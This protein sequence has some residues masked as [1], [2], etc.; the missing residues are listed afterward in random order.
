MPVAPGSEE[1][2]DQRV[3]NG[4]GVHLKKLRELREFPHVFRNSLRPIPNISR[5]PSSPAA[6]KPIFV[7]IP[8]DHL[9]KKGALMQKANV[10]HGEKTVFMARKELPSVQR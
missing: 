3:Y 7:V 8:F 6:R 10:S 2:N 1:A 9:R 5:C 4:M